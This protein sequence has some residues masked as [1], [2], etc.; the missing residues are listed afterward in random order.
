MRARAAAALVEGALQDRGA[1]QNSRAPVGAADLNSRLPRARHG[2]GQPAGATATGAPLLPVRNR[3]KFLVEQG[4]HSHGTFTQR[5]IIA[6]DSRRLDLKLLSGVAARP[7]STFVAEG[8]GDDAPEGTCGPH[9]AEENAAPP[10]QVWVER[11]TVD[12]P[13]EEQRRAMRGHDSRGREPGNV[14][15]R[16]ETRV[17]PRGV[18]PIVRSRLSGVGILHRHGRS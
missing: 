5:V 17:V 13:L 11:Q 12:P 4:R 7:T 9:E 8:D 10:R 18:V 14:T 2:G 16:H 3:I 1:L 6:D 15:R